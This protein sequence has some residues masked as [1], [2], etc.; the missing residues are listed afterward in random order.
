[1]NIKLPEILTV[2]ETV[3]L[4]NLVQVLS[5]LGLEVETHPGGPRDPNI[6]FTVAQKGKILLTDVKVI[7]H[8]RD[9]MG[10]PPVDVPDPCAFNERFINRESTECP[11]NFIEQEFRSQFSPPKREHMSVASNV[12][13]FRGKPKSH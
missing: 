2:P 11:I 8:L 3:P 4:L 5:Y 9:A 6:N 7:N 10:L 1:M 12:V 13:P